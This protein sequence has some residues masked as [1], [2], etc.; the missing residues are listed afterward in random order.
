MSLEVFRVDCRKGALDVPRVGG[1]LAKVAFH[2][3]E[4]EVFIAGHAPTATAFRLPCVGGIV[5][6]VSKGHIDGQKSLLVTW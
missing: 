6:L 1:C 2:V 5:L 4:G 3:A